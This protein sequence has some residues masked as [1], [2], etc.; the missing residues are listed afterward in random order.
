[1]RYERKKQTLELFDTLKEALQF[2]N[3]PVASTASYLHDDCLACVSAI[4]TVFEEVEDKSYMHYC[5]DSENAIHSNEYNLAYNSVGLWAAWLKDQVKAHY[6]IVFMPYKADMWD[7]FDS[8]WRAAK[9]DDSCVVRTVPIP[10]YTLDAHKNPVK[11]EYEGGK[12]PAY[13]DVTHYNDYDV[14]TQNPDVIFIHNP[15]DQYNTITRVEPK[16]FSTNLAKYTDKLVYIPYFIALGEYPE[17]FNLPTMRVAWRIFVQSDWTRNEFISNHIH[18]DKVVA[19]GSPKIDY[20]Y[21]QMNELGDITKDWESR[22]N[23]KKVFLFNTSIGSFLAEGDHAVKKIEEVVRHFQYNK[24]LAI[25]WRPHPLLFEMIISMRPH[26]KNA[27]L[28]VVSKFKKLN[29]AIFDESE[30][31]YKAI[32][33]SDAYI[34]DYSSVMVPFAVTGKPILTLPPYIKESFKHWGTSS[35][36]LKYGEELTIPLGA[37]P[38]KIYEGKYFFIA[39]NR[40]GLFSLNIQS[41]VT[42]K[43]DCQDLLQYKEPQ[44]FID[45]YL[46]EHAA[47]FIPYRANKV[48][49]YN[50]GTKV[51]EEYDIPLE[52]DLDNSYQFSCSIQHGVYVW[53][54]PAQSHSAV[55]LDMRSGEM[56]V[57]NL[58]Q[59]LTTEQ[60]DHIC[61]SAAILDNKLWVL[62]GDMQTVISLNVDTGEVLDGSIKQFDYQIRSVV[63]TDD[64]LW[65]LQNNSSNIIIWDPEKNEMSQ[66]DKWP[67]V[68]KGGNIPFS[69]GTY[70]GEFVWLIPHDANSVIKISNNTLEVSIML[71]KLKKS[72]WSVLNA[73]YP[74]DNMQRNKSLRESYALFTGAIIHEDWIWLS[75]NA[76][77]EMIGFHLV[78]GEVKRFE[79]KRD[80][81]MDEMD[82]I[83][84]KFPEPEFN[85]VDLRRTFMSRNL[86]VKAFINMVCN[87][88]YSFW[89]FSQKKEVCRSLTNGEGSSGVAIW[90]YI[91]HQ[92][93]N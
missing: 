25:I 57:I 45:S 69:S 87:E 84:S 42:E 38:G 40:G 75:P 66:F 49:R 18:P 34:G 5:I 14:S 27:Y 28:S 19:L 91:I 13:V 39:W 82:V 20:V 43:I 88:S 54:L 78:T 56:K 65:L 93:E 68:F 70:D 26:L 9:N 3:S 47:W 41:G 31:M 50:L 73:S 80:R 46:N 33:Y 63:A 1:M 15:Y 81:I 4:K 71:S 8:V 6:H 35:A 11:F 89:N 29:N 83:L 24:E 51:L 77:S 32:I 76:A 36:W 58:P 16:Y 44:L 21:R 55:K 22:L 64:K 37:S 7:A 85:K 52:H 59:V 74:F 12:L 48:L 62:M 30:D 90:D 10:Y 72:E 79:L 2:L 17:H 67:K 92:L 53:L 86:P 61:M 60:I 23:G